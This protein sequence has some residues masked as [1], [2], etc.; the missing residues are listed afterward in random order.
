MGVRNELCILTEK[1]T[2]L[3]PLM[4]SFLVITGSFSLGQ[5]FAK[6]LLSTPI[7]I[8]FAAEI[9][10]PSTKNPRRTRRKEKEKRQKRS[11]KE[12]EEKEKRRKREGEEK[13]KR[14]S[15]ETRDISWN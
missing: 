2:V 9:S 10:V 4:T 12:A 11:R 13:E 15:R 1:S 6:M 3:L 7:Q 14:S 5:Y 8:S